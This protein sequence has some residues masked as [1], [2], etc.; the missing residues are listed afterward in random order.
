L[1]LPDPHN[2]SDL[3][4]GLIKQMKAFILELGKGDVPLPFNE[5]KPEKLLCSLTGFT[6]QII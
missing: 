4:K 2:E 3:Q 1:N 5:A 6:P